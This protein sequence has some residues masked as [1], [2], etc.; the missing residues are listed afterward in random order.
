MTEQATSPLTVEEIVQELRRQFPGEVLDAYEF[1]GQW[2][3]LVRRDRIVE[4]CKFLRDDPRLAFNHLA[5][6]TA[7]DYLP[8]TPRFEVVYNLYSLKYRHRIR[9][10]VPLE[11]HDLWVD[12]LTGLWAAANFLEREVYDLFGI[13]FRNHPDLRRIMMPDDWEGHPLRKDYPGESPEG[14]IRERLRLD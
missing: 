3:V 5:D 13:T 14:I 2:N 11:E 12:S 4:I 9:L 7:V 8:R 10:K 1:A 6:L